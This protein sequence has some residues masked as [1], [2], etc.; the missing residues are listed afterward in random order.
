MVAIGMTDRSPLTWIQAISGVG[1]ISHQKRV[2]GRRDVYRLAVTR[3]ADILSLLCRVKPY[4][5][6]KEAEANIVIIS[7]LLRGVKGHLRPFPAVDN[8]LIRLSTLLKGGD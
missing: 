1:N 5:H 8:Y 4:L 3:G 7:L 2:G 6:L